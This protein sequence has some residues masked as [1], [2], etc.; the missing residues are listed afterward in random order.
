MNRVKVGFFSL[1]GHATRGD[2][3]PYLRWHQLDHMPEQYQLPGLVFGQRWGAT[4]A[5]R[6]ARVS[7][8]GPWSAV[9]NVVLY[10]MG[11]PLD[12]TLD[13]FLAL[14]RRLAEMG[15]FPERLPSC[16]QGGLRLLETWASPAA[17]VSPDVVPFRPNRGIYLIVEEAT[18]RRRYDDHLRRVHAE[19]LPGLVS[20]PGVAGLWVFA[21]SSAIRRPNFD[22]GEYR[23]TVCYLDDD[24]PVVAER[25]REPLADA[26]A[27]APVRPLLA[28]PYETVSVWDLDRFAPAGATPAPS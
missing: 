7:A 12:E 14:G 10:L 16:Y 17:L 3:R 20:V 13:E 19:V 11:E 25:L 1:S 6:P 2:D 5:C 26:W 24:P 9:E 21:T 22:D 23:I 28:A 27:A 18:D 4:A 15:R 8:A